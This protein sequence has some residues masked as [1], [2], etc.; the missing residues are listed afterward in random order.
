MMRPVGFPSHVAAA[1][2]DFD[3]TMIDL[4]AQHTGAYAALAR[5]LGD[6]YTRMPEHFRFASGKR[7][8]DD[9]H[10]M[11]EFFGWQQPLDELFARRQEHFAAALREAPLA[12]LPGVERTVR[13]LRASGI[14]L[15]IT[16]SAV[17]A[18]IEEVLRR[19]ALRDAFALIVD[20][21]QVTRPKPD[22]EPYL[23]TARQLGVEPRQC[24]VFEDSQVGVV[25]AKRAAMYC[26]AVRNP[27]AKTHQ[28][29][30]AADLL[31]ESLD[32]FDPAWVTPVAPKGC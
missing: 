4:E 32:D 17:G 31:L 20:G 5:E 6:D 10:D 3:E 23:V 29:L 18:S 15:A 22:P 13:A 26:V 2:F 11:R 1:I 25:A 21:S 9:V 8:I 14:T 27:H 16:S 28:D 30:S 7:V 12:L 19:F 24:I